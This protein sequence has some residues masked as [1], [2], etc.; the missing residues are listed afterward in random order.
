VLVS[1]REQGVL[2]RLSTTPVPSARVL[3]AQ[4]AVNLVLALAAILPS[5]SAEL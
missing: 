5:L 3:G 2:R 1:Y 4:L